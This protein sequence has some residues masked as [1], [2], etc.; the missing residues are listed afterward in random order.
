MNAIHTLAVIFLADAVLA[1][2]SA[3]LAELLMSQPP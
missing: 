3:G 2:V 1:L